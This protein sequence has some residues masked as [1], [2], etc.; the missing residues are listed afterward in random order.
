MIFKRWNTTAKQHADWISQHQEFSKYERAPAP[1][2][3]DNTRHTE[4]RYDKPTASLA[5]TVPTIGTSETMQP[6]RVY[7]PP[8]A[9]TFVEM[10]FKS[11][12][13]ASCS[14][15]LSSMPRSLGGERINPQC[16]HAN[17]LT[18]A[19]HHVCS[20]GVN[21]SKEN[22]VNEHTFAGSAAQDATFPP[23]YPKQGQH[24]AT[25]AV[26]HYRMFSCPVKGVFWS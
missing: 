25:F 9:C 24:W 19:I 17:S 13:I 20:H 15:P 12:A 1:C 10:R 3:R 7:V 5:G 23:Q 14:S 11:S 22:V 2:L 16:N 18:A 26:L 21:K 8:L 4:G 6:K